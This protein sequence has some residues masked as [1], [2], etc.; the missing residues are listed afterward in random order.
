MIQ[1]SCFLFCLGVIYAGIWCTP[2]IRGLGPGTWLKGL[3]GPTLFTAGSLVVAVKKDD[4][5]LAIG[6]VITGLVVSY[7]AGSIFALFLSFVSASQR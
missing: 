4:L 6:L 5:V 1:I 3:V 7:V 2:W